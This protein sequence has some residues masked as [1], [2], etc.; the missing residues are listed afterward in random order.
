MSNLEERRAEERAKY[1]AIYAG[2]VVGKSEEERKNYAA[3]GHNNHGRDAWQVVFDLHPRSICDVGTG[4]GEFPR[5]CWRSSLFS[6]VYGF[7]FALSDKVAETKREGT[8]TL[9][10]LKAPAHALPIPDKSI[11]LLTSFD[12]LEHL[13]EEEV[14]DVFREFARVTRRHML[15]SI[16]T[17]PSS[18]KVEGKTLHPTVRPMPWWLK[19]IED[20]TKAVIKPVRSNKYLLCTLPEVAS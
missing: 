17:R 10:I 3:Y 20:V 18:I 6:K 4:G 19:Q 12:M 1:E 15:F 16:S 7:D 11:D 9:N 2:K 14:P 5:M 13:V 8:R